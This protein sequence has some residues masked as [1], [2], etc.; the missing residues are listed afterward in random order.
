MDAF[1][2]SLSPTELKALFYMFEFWA[3]PHQ[4]PPAGDWRTWVVMGGRGA[5]KTRAGAEW[6]RAQAEG[7][8]PRLAGAC[9]R[10][11]IV[12]ETFDQARD[13][14]VF[15][16][17][18][19]MAVSPPAF[20]PEWIASRRQLIWP[21]GAMAQVYSAHDPESLRGPQFDAL[22]ADELA[23]WKTAE[24]AWDMLQFALRLGEDPRACVTTTPR[25]SSTLR[26]LLARDS[27]V[28]THAP[29]QANSANLAPGFL[30]E[31][32]ARYAGT[33]MGR[34][35]LEGIMMMEVEGALWTSAMVEAAMCD[36][37]PKLDRIIVAVDPAASHNAKSDACGIIVAGVRHCAETD[38][39]EAYVLEDAS[40]EG[41][42]PNQ[43]AEAA[44]AAY[45]RHGADRIV[46]EVNQGGAMVEAVVRGVAPTVSY[47]AVHASKGKALRAEPVAALYEQG[48]VKHV[49][50][51]G[52]LEDEMCA[53]TMRGYEG[54]GSPDRMDALVWALHELIITPALKWRAPRM[55]G[56]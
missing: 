9:K 2:E 33:R 43:W 23:K 42:T 34:Q 17:S 19:V 54:K 45:D 26:D 21:N 20:R 4:L 44:V 56:L 11:A 38:T 5:G 53:M 35:E 18:G 10:I 41:A 51:L 28:M 49:R 52:A 55:R 16:D 50:G 36:N 31:V 48:R 46:A 3:L 40:L 29:T 14:M 1:L 32:Q 39:A 15:G 25:V 22:W 30:R 13:V 37:V 24:A 7:P 6:V 27:T 47:K 8:R 12:G